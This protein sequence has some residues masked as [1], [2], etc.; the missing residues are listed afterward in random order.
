MLTTKEAIL[1]RRSI[2][3]YKK[4]PVPEEIIATLL[5][6]ARWAPSGCNAQPWRFK[7]ATEPTLKKSL[8]EAAY[9]QAFIAQA[10]LVMVCCA[11][12]QG[13]LDSTVSG[14]QDLGKLGAVENRLVKVLEH[15]TAQMK[16]LPLEQV[17]PLVAINVAIAIEHMVLRALDYGLGSC[18]VRLFDVDEVKKIFDWDDNIFP[19][20]LLPIGFPAESPPI[21]KRKPS[22]DLVL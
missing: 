11:D 17:G 9:G 16:M 5:E 15:R 22:S 3:K 20:A 18:W 2:R 12:I 7:I 1:K 8:S 6:A 4:D 21:K 14:A 19:V 13:Y 10:P